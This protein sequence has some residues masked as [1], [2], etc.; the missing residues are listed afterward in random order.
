MDTHLQPLH[1]FHGNPYFFLGERPFVE[2]ELRSHIVRQH[3][4]GRQIREICED[5]RLLELGPPSLWLKVLCEPETIAA[6][7]ADVRES[8]R[9]CR[10]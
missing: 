1:S 9:S 10:P 5:S 6:L 2:S 4:L 7:A 3:R 8:I